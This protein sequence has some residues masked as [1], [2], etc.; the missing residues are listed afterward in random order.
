MSNKFVPH[1]RPN[2]KHNLE[3]Q[4]NFAS[5]G[6]RGVQKNSFYYR[7]IEPWNK[8]TSEDVTSPSVEIFKKRLQNHWKHEKYIV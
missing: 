5:D 1:I 8:L 4:R 3:L 2:R 6:Y 7:S